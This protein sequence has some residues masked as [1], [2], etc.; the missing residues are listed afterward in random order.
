MVY[1]LMDVIQKDR[2]LPCVTTTDGIGEDIVI[3]FA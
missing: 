2:K 1:V 3:N